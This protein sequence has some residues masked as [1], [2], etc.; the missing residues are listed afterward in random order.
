[1]KRSCQPGF[2][3]STERRAVLYARYSSERQADSWSI[4][5]QVAELRAYCERM[6]WSVLDEVCLDQA[7]SGSTTERPGLTRA[8]DLIRA[9]RANVL[10][11]H[12]LDHFFRDMART[13]EYVRELEDHGGGLVCT[14]QPIDTTNPV[15]GKIVLAVMA[16]LAEIY[17]DNLS[18]ET[19]KGKRARAATGL[20]NGDLPYGYALSRQAE[21]P[22]ANNRA[23]AQIMPEEAEAIRQ[24]FTWYAS[25]Q[26]GEATIAKRL[27]E[28]G[29][30]MRSKR[31]LTGGLFTRDTLRSMLRNPFYA[32]WVRQPGDDAQNWAE[33]AAIG[34][35]QRGLHEPIISQDLYDLVQRVRAE[36]W[37][38]P[39]IGGR[40][41]GAAPKR[42][43]APYIAAGLIRC[44][45]CGQRLHGQVA[46]SGKSSYF[47]TWHYRG[48][49]CTTQRKSREAVWI[50]GALGAAITG[51]QLPPDWRDRILDDLDASASI[52]RQQSAARAALERK[53]AR[54][55]A[56]LIDGDLEQLE[57]RSERSRIERELINL[58]PLKSVTGVEDAVALLADL[59]E[60]WTT[61]EV[62]DQRE[63]AATAFEAAYI[64]LD[65][66]DAGITCSLKEPLRP[67]RPAL[68]G[69]RWVTDGA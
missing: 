26:M 20:P 58:A 61:G 1:M 25:G 50:D 62:E 68:D 54:L 40:K 30:H 56:L 66:P 29:Y 21:R 60:L 67:L 16:A 59:T 15:S 13:F 34:D 24:A 19:A 28:Y 47:C 69:C 17:L 48:G 39:G 42:L 53:L 5:A 37:G 52:V 31:G 35:K 65:N 10:V 3:V 7:I 45:H 11:V 22:G 4:D 55:K 36:R 6:A 64:D 12:K 2:T 46:G 44:F 27:N 14:Q 33:R 49:T 23:A 57:Y 63:L 51:M 41:R 8:M 43:H 18:E 38:D 9:G 32:G